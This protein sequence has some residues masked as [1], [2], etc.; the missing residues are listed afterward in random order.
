MITAK[1][2]NIK[3]NA[4]VQNLKNKAA[5]WV[6]DEWEFIDS[7]IQKAIEK[8]EFEASYWWS[9]ELL[10]DAGVEKR[11]VAQAL[12]EKAFNL[13]F[14]QEVVTNYSNANVLRIDIRWERA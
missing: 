14:H 8:G 9:N 11:Y 3:T 6:E 1:E 12:R 2:A 5:A 7:Q 10:K 4:V 13:G